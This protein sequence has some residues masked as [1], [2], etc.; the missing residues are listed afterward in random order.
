MGDA[1]VPEDSG[2]QLGEEDEA[3]A[4]QLFGLGGYGYHQHSPFAAGYLDPSQLYQQYP[5]YLPE[6]DIQV[7]IY[8]H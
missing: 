1:A 7:Q 4:K 5:Q 2:V 8:S 3:K 6:I